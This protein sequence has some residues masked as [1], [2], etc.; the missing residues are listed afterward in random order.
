MI[1]R[2]GIS[3]LRTP[4]V[5]DVI[6][7]NFKIDYHP[8]QIA[9]DEPRFNWIIQNVDVAGKRVFDLGAS[10][11]YFSLRLAS[12]YDAHVYACEPISVYADL[13]QMFTKICRLEDRLQVKKNSITIDDLDSLPETDL[14]L[15]L[16]ILHHAGV[17]YDQ[18]RVN[19]I[20]D[21]RKYSQDY[22]QK[23]SEKT[24]VLLIQFANVWN[25]TV[26]FD[27]SETV[28]FTK[29]LLSDSGWRVHTIGA[30]S[31]FD[32]LTYETFAASDCDCIVRVAIMRNK[33]TNLVDY[34][35]EGKHVASFPTGLAQRPLWLCQSR[36]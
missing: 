17:Q 34:T 22:L 36:K 5:L 16:N 29:E 10:L 11:G 7:K 24:N 1:N 26:I 12:E 28:P 25:D 6:P 27:S 2:F 32:S 21:W 14:F 15:H 4:C 31:D 13:I 33:E 3:S 20:E 18:H 19:S 9:L 8:K 35:I 30:I 23:L